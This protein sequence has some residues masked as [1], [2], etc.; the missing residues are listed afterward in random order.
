[1]FEQNQDIFNTLSEALSEGVIIVDKTQ[2]I[3][4]VNSSTNEMFGY[5]SNELTGKSLEVLIPYFP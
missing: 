5:E 3:V 4:G 2:K 1:M